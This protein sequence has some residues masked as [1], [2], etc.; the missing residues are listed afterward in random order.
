MGSRVTK[1]WLQTQ[2]ICLRAR[3]LGTSFLILLRSTKVDHHRVVLRFYCVSRCPTVF[4]YFTYMVLGVQKNVSY[5]KLYCH[6]FYRGGKVCLTCT[7]SMF[8]CFLNRTFFIKGP[9]WFYHFFLFGSLGPNFQLSLP[10]RL[11]C[12]QLLLLKLFLGGCLI[13][14]L[15]SR[16]PDSILDTGPLL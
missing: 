12:W 9:T 5:Y 15:R 3:R 11:W 8:V 16:R 1:V 14:F 13:W 4:V 7:I 10:S 6:C 2:P